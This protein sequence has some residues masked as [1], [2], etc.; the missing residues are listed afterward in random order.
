MIFLMNYYYNI[1]L[2]YLVAL[3]GQAEKQL[4]AYEASSLSSSSLSAF[5]YQ[6]VSM[7]KLKQQINEMNECVSGSGDQHQKKST[8]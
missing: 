7:E 8:L 5:K 3:Y 1:K 4:K 6:S 2:S